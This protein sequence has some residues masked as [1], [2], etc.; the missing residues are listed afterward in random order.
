MTTKIPE[1]LDAKIEQWVRD[2]LV[3]QQPAVKAAVERAF[4]AT[5]V[6]APRVAGSPRSREL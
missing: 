5:T 6:P 1:A 2:H 4:A 3:S